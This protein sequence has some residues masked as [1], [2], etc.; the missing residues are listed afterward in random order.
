MKRHNYPYLIFFT[1]CLTSVSANVCN[2]NFNLYPVYAGGS[3]SEYVNCMVHD[4]RNE[5]II[6]GGNTTSTD[7]G[8]FDPDS[9]DSSGFLYALDYMGNWIWGIQFSNLTIFLGLISMLL[10]FSYPFMN[11]F[12]FGSSNIPVQLCFSSKYN[13]FEVVTKSSAPDSMKKPFWTLSLKIILSR[14]SS[15]WYSAYFFKVGTIPDVSDSG[16]YRMS[17]LNALISSGSSCSRQLR[18]G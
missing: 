18:P 11:R 13:V 16:G 15:W 3:G 2:S 5:L 1:V 12:G 17:F 6:V 4:E 8:L 9:A 14:N 10:A 7:F